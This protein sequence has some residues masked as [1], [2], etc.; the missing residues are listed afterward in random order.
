MKNPS[1]KVKQAESIKNDYR[2]FPR[3]ASIRPSLDG[4]YITFSLNESRTL[5][6]SVRT[7]Y[8]LRILETAQERM[9]SS[10]GEVA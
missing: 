5:S 6:I 10:K 2:P 8:L 4:K 9:N 7:A 1:S 3:F